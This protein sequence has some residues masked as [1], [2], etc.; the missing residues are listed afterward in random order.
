[1]IHDSAARFWFSSSNIWECQPRS[2]KEE[3]R[4][5]GLKIHIRILT[6]G[7]GSTFS[8]IRE[9]YIWKKRYLWAIY[10]HPATD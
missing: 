5:I 1:M 10:P 6:W 4:R 8:V 7:Q 2:F 3:T 9:F